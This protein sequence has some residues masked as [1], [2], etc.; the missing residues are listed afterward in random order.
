M[1]QKNLDI[2]QSESTIEAMELWMYRRIDCVSWKQKQNR[3]LRKAGN[4]RAV[5]SHNKK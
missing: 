2:E 4:E 5:D 1:I 3:V